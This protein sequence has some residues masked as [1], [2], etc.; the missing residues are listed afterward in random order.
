MAQRGQV[1]ATGPQIPKLEIWQTVS[2]LS[3]PAPFFTPVLLAECVPDN[4]SPIGEL[5][6]IVWNDLP[7]IP[8]AFVSP[9]WSSSA[10]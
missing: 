9:D 2:Y 4:M 3:F 10:L 5:S 6:I 7:I 8:M 1:C